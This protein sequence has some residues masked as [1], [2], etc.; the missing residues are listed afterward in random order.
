[1]SE[2][3]TPKEIVEEIAKCFPNFLA[4]SWANLIKER[5]E[6]ALTAERE[7]IKQLE[8]EKFKKAD[9]QN[10][11]LVHKKFFEQQVERIKEL[12]AE[13]KDLNKDL[14]ENEAKLFRIAEENL[15]MREA[16]DQWLECKC[17]S[18]YTCNAC[19]VKI[20][21]EHTT[22]LAKQREADLAVIAKLLESTKVICEGDTVFNL[23]VSRVENCRCQ[24]E[25]C[26]Q[27]TLS[28]SIINQVETNV[29]S[30]DALA[31]R[32]KIYGGK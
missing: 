2:M 21:C 11:T 7:R 13:I 31:A 10:Y 15:R 16:L 24:H 30:L 29:R 6:K 18:D 17:I 5:T 9:G 25:T 12:E 1:M 19:L 20:S 22:Q 8:A 3:K 23:A 14:E 26:E 4:G 28:R 32:E 27:C